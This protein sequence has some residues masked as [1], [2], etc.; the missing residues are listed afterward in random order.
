MARFGRRSIIQHERCGDERFGLLRL[1]QHVVLPRDDEEE[2]EHI[3][4]TNDND[5]VHIHSARHT[6]HASQ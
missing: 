4:S 2:V 6:A 5:R 1:L 3:E